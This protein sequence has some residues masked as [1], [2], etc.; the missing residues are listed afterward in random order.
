MLL[1]AKEYHKIHPWQATYDTWQVIHDIH[2]TSIKKVSLVGFCIRVV[3]CHF[4]F[5]IMDFSF[6]WKKNC[7]VAQSVKYGADTH[8]KHWDENPKQLSCGFW[9]V[10]YFGIMWTYP[11]TRLDGDHSTPHVSPSN[12]AFSCGPQPP[13]LHRYTYH[14]GNL[15]T[16]FYV[17]QKIWDQIAGVF[18]RAEK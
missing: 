17:Y 8:R 2:I 18:F 10:I 15:H 6:L 3:T 4:F 14:K 9:R 7:A 16:T 1:R 13:L 12:L 5:R 11:R